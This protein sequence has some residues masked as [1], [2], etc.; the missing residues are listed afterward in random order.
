MV[1]PERFGSGVAN[2]Y[3]FR[4]ALRA[5]GMTMKGAQGV[6]RAPAVRR[7]RDDEM[8][9]INKACHSGAARAVRERNPTAF[10]GANAN[11]AGGAQRERQGWR[12]SI[13]LVW[14]EWFSPGTVCEDGS[15]LHCARS[16]S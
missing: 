10:A 8:A 3:R 12:E 7:D 9:R 15:G 13:G 11:A 1:C 2:E 5:S 4:I 16:A 14:P 6:Y